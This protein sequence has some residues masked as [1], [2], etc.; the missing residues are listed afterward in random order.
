MEKFLTNLRY[1]RARKFQPK[2][3]LALLLLCSTAIVSCKNNEQKQ[4]AVETSEVYGFEQQVFCL[5]MLSNISSHYNKQ[6][7]IKDS[8][9]SAVTNVLASEDVQNV[10]GEWKCVWGPDVVALDKKATNTMFVAR[11]GAT[12]TFVV[13]IAGTDP[14]SC[15]DWFLEDFNVKKKL[16]WDGFDDKKGNITAATMTGL[17]ILKAM[18]EIGKERSVRAFLDDAADS[19]S[20]INVW[21]TGHS[22]G[23]A[24]APV[25][26]LHLNNTMKSTDVNVHCLAVAGATPGDKQFADYYESVLGNST[27]RVWNTRDLV[28][29]GYE[30]DMLEKVPEMY[31]DS[32]HKMPVESQ[33]LLDGVILSCSDKEYTQ[34][35][36]NDTRSFTS[37]IYKEDSLR[38]AHGKKTF[39]DSLIHT[40]FGQAIFHHIPAYGEYFKTINFQKAVQK[41]LGLPAPF[42]TE[43]AF[44]M[45]VYNENNNAN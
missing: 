32:V 36:P 22:L 39:T 3:A 19:L 15:T 24:L 13:A 37:A 16:P 45:P 40:F 5:N 44:V 42:F 27:T 34:L 20:G 29:H 6:E 2:R 7:H 31:G 41:T 35:R 18:S 9:L 4:D 14:T 11:K 12:D 25:Y 1:W 17:T 10:I 21:V 26:A 43:G 28:P 30:T 38:N 33:A 23:G 8:T